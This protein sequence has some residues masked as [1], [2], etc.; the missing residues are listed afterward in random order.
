VNRFEPHIGFAHDAAMWLLSEFA[1]RR[2]ASPEALASEILAGLIKLRLGPFSRRFEAS[3]LA[4]RIEREPFLVETTV[5]LLRGQGLW[6]VDA[7]AG[8]ACCREIEAVIREG[9]PA[10]GVPWEL[11]AGAATS[12]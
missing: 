7:Q 5:Y 11:T 9:A 2:R 8:R 10:V 12:R 4:R 1:E 6:P 3:A